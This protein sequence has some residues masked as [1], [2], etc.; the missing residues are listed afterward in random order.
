MAL[1]LLAIGEL[2]GHSLFGHKGSSHAKGLLNDLSFG[3]Q[4][5][6]KLDQLGTDGTSLLSQLASMLQ[7]GTPMATIIDRVAKA[8]SN[9]LA[10]ATG[11]GGDVTRRRTL[12]RALAAALAPPGTSPPNQSR[13]QQAAALERRL[14]DLLSKISREMTSA[15]QQ[16]RFS[17]AV[18][19]AK[20]AREIPAQQMNQST[21]NTP[22]ASLSFA[23]SILQSVMQ[24]LQQDA[25]Q[26]APQ[27][28]T[29][30]AAHTATA[31]AQQIT[32]QS[33]DVLGRML[34]RAA[35]AD[36]QHAGQ[37][38]APAAAVTTP[39]SS[40]HASPSDLFARL[41]TAITQSSSENASRQGGKQSEEFAF[42]NRALPVLHHTP[43]SS[44]ATPAAA[45]ATATLNASA[46][47]AQP[48]SLPATPYTIDPQAVIEQVVKG[49]V[50]R[51]AGSTS[52]LRMRL[53]PEHL[54]DVSL[55]LTVTGSTITANIIAQN[56]D[57]RHALL[58]NQQQLARSLA[59]AGLSLGKFSVDVS[60][61]NPGFSQQQSQHHR[62]LS[63]AGALHIAALAEDDT[64][65]DPFAP[66]VLTGARPL[67][68]NH[69]A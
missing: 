47:A 66:P 21:G 64:W 60:G 55:K 7:A 48:G 61:G 42:A 31:A 8:V 37:T 20:P 1:P 65:A 5:Q 16:K 12:E 28:A 39:P 18:L 24:Q 30:P 17:G 15:G 57:V 23:E 19:D 25:S 43:A 59:E 54:G 38:A 4:L 2:V 32:V 36:V 41:V 40:T 50:L 68:L 33:T 14:G 11:N 69:L 67:V 58:S 62:S 10:N 52:E 27:T 53:Q 56:A 34:A 3:S 13:V 49:I 6:R 46:P 26:A 29:Q 22:A 63:K 35:S 9:A 51:N 45:F 44:N